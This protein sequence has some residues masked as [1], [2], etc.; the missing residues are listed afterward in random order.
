MDKVESERGYLCGRWKRQRFP[1]PVWFTWQ[2]FC[3]SLPEGS[4][5]KRL[6]GV[7]PAFL[8]TTL[9]QREMDPF[10]TTGKVLSGL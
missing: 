3:A 6:V 5:G 7:K 10:R 9:A 2:T 4:T 1:S 8:A